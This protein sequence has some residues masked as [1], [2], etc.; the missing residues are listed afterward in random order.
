MKIL[1]PMIVIAALALATPMLMASEQDRVDR[2]TRIVER[3]KAMPEKQIPRHVLR[4]AEG[5]AVISMAKG[6]FVFS[7]RVGDG[8]VMAR[9]GHGW[10]GPS[11]I[12]TGGIGFG[13]QIGGQVT[14]MVLVLNTPAAVKAFIRDGN[15]ELGGALS[16][17]AG[18]MGRDA[19]AGVM[20]KAAVYTYSLSK[21]L[22]AGASLEGTVFM[23]D[24]GANE[25]YYHRPVSA[26]AILSGKVA[27]PRGA[28]ELARSV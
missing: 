7:G 6:G 27:R 18:P 14:D 15:V 19:E 3:F 20:P 22:F 13:A 21:G 24:K 10:S 2:A 25:R 5:I 12:H 9:T 4:E 11:F 1:K 26:S 28:A 16:V 17:A 8:I 23:T